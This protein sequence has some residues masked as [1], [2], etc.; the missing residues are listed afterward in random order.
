MAVSV[1]F[2]AVYLLLVKPRTP[3]FLKRKFVMPVPVKILALPLVVVGAAIYFW[4]V[5]I[6]VGYSIPLNHYTVANNPLWGWVNRDWASGMITS[7]FSF[8]SFQNCPANVVYDAQYNQY[9]T[10]LGCSSLGCIGFLFA[11][12]ATAGVTMMELGK[13]FVAAVRNAFTYFALPA[14]LVLQVGLQLY[15]SKDMATHVS[16]FTVLAINGVQ[17]VS[18]NFVLSL[19]VCLIFGSCVVLPLIDVS[20]IGGEGGLRA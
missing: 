19:V 16:N 1:V 3:A 13:G 6:T 11:G 20:Q 4:T 15:D 7:Y 17:V 14:V 9:Y 2:L 10:L 12:V 8:Q 5:L 18:N